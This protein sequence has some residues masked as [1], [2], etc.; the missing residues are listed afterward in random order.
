MHPTDSAVH[1]HVGSSVEIPIAT[2]RT[3][4][5][6]LPPVPHPGAVGTASVNNNRTFDAPAATPLHALLLPAANV[7]G[8]GNGHAV[9]GTGRVQLA[10]LSPASV[11]PAPKSGAPDAVVVPASEFTFAAPARERLATLGAATPASLKTPV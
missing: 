11:S 6:A 5:A 9:N 8:T 7:N 10:P 1:L 2:E 4:A 3:G